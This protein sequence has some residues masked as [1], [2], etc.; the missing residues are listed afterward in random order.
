MGIGEGDLIEL[1]CYI[2]ISIYINVCIYLY[3]QCIPC[4]NIAA[5]RRRFL[6]VLPNSQVSYLMTGFDNTEDISS[7]GVLTSA[8]ALSKQWWKAAL[9]ISLVWLE[10]DVEL[11]TT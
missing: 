7:F 2:Y 1:K 5:S 11:N 3:T 10:Y 6:L 4:K 8:Y 9:G